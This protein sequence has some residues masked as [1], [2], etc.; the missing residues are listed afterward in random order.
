[1]ARWWE[2]GRIVSLPNKWGETDRA[3]EESAIYLSSYLYQ[4]SGLT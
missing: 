1:M 2:G 3:N 4:Y